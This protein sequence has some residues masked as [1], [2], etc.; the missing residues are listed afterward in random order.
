MAFEFAIEGLIF[1]SDTIGNA[2]ISPCE[3]RVFPRTV[4]YNSMIDDTSIGMDINS[5]SLCLSYGNTR[6]H[7]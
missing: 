3:E 7:R 5:W 1:G 2:P 4:K 6:S